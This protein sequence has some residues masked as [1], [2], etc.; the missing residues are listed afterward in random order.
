ML[1]RNPKEWTGEMLVATRKQAE[2]ESS[3]QNALEKSNRVDR[4]DSHSDTKTETEFSHKSANGKSKREDQRDARSDTKA[5][6]SPAAPRLPPPARDSMLTRRPQER[7]GEIPAATRHQA[8]R[9]APAAPAPL[10]VPPEA[11]NLAHRSLR[12]KDK[13]STTP[14][15]PPLARSRYPSQLPAL[16]TFSNIEGIAANIGLKQEIFL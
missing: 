15:T 12:Y 10:P 8:R 2:T 9:P 5:G 6:K 3:L 11:V 13:R 16:R 1:A 7:T 14:S 4:R